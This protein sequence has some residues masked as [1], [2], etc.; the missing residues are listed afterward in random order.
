MSFMAATLLLNMETAEAFIAFANIMNKP[1]Q[2]AFYR[3]DEAQVRSLLV[4]L[5]LLSRADF[6]C[7]KALCTQCKNVEDSSCLD[8]VSFHVLCELE[9][10][11]DIRVLLSAQCQTT[12]I[13]HMFC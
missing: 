12:M 8:C 10:V 3:L 6:D 2:V 7:F 5:Y 11:L 13:V 4:M 1:C 9:Q